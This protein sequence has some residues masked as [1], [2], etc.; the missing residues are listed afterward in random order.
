MIVEFVKEYSRPKNFWKSTYETILKTDPTNAHSVPKASSNPATLV[1]ICERT[2]MNVH[3]YAMFVVKHSSNHVNSNS[4]WDYILVKSRISVKNVIGGSNRPV[5]STSTSD[6][7][8]EK[9][10]TS[11]W[12]AIRPLRRQANYDRTRKPMNPNQREKLQA[13]KPK[14][15][16]HMSVSLNQ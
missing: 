7:T 1:S 5:S 11:V 16:F 15:K 14:V 8:L 10:H 9:N 4:T 13:T 6:C 3:F 12:Y 2:Q